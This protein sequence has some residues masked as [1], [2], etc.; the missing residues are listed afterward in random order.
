MNNAKPL[1]I[2]SP[3][4][5]SNML[6]MLNLQ[7]VDVAAKC[8]A[9]EDVTVI[10]VPLPDGINDINELDEHEKQYH[11]PI[12]TTVDFL[13]ARTKTGPGWHGYTK[14]SADLMFVSVLYDIGF[15]VLVFD[16]E[17]KNPNDL[18]GKKIG[19]PPRASSVR[20]LSEALLRDGWGILDDVELVDIAPPNVQKALEAGEI[21]ATTWNFVRRNGDSYISLLPGLLE[22][23]A[24][25]WLEVDR[26]AVSA[27]NKHNPFV[28]GVSVMGAEKESGTGALND[29]QMVSFTQALAAWE[30]TDAVTVRALLGCIHN[31]LGQYDALPQEQAGMLKWPGLDLG[32][33]HPAA[34][35]FY[36][37]HGMIQ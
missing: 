2:Y 23:E 32:H 15:G 14:A 29:I 24:S 36:R 27:I 21:D 25:H 31:Q 6:H 11:L 3:A 37:L 5:P 19:V 10:P 28:V 35:A 7:L 26:E 22:M 34:A 17:I 8:P 12:V 16:S 33:L 1:V 20:M 4:P 13:P 30:K 18:K 9:L